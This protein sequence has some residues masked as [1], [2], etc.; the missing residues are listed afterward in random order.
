MVILKEHFGWC[1]LKFKEE[2]KGTP[3]ESVVQ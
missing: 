2:K 3:Y 1:P